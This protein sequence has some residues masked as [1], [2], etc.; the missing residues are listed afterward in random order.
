MWMW[1]R[2][3]WRRLKM[4]L[5]VK[6]NFQVFLK[7]P[8]SA[9]CSTEAVLCF[10]VIVKPSVL[11]HCR[12]GV[13]KSIQSVKIEWWGAVVVIVWS[14]VQIV[15]IWSSWCHFIPKPHHLLP[16]FNPEW[17]LPLWYWLTQVV[18]F[19][20]LCMCVMFTYQIVAKHLSSK[21]VFH[22]LKLSQRTAVFYQIGYWSVH[23]KWDLLLQVVVG[24][25]KFLTGLLLLAIYCLKFRS[26]FSCG[27]PSDQL[28]STII[29]TLL[30]TVAVATIYLNN[31]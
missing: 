22:V 14:E 18:S 7:V 24:L 29:F 1:R 13:R 12:F 21:L 25:R 5:E 10:C 31:I 19:C 23:W 2:K 26:V 30:I 15:C 6:M 8:V 9:T 20:R 28:K 16:H 17:L 3:L 27:W 4:N 11:W